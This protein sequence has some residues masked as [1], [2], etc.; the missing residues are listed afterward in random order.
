MVVTQYMVNTEHIIHIRTMWA[1]DM[2]ITYMHMRMCIT[3]RWPTLMW[4]AA[5]R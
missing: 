4:S 3:R 2:C 1:A 5:R